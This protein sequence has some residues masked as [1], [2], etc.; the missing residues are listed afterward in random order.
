LTALFLFEDISVG[1][2]THVS[3]KHHNYV[4]FQAYSVMEML[5]IEFLTAA[6]VQDRD[7]SRH[8][9]KSDA[10]QFCLAV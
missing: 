1:C 2:S 4:A 6:E 9:Q 5:V 3:A 8:A 7:N 10:K